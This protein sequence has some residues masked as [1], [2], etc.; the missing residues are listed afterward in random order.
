MR[1][2]PEA[3]TASSSRTLAR[4]L[5]DVGRHRRSQVGDPASAPS[6]PDRRLHARRGARQ[7]VG[8]R[9][10]V[11][12]SVSRSPSTGSA[13]S[14]PAAMTVTAVTSSSAPRRAHSRRAAPVACLS[15]RHPLGG[16]AVAYVA[17]A[18]RAA[19]RWRPSPR[20]CRRSS[21]RPRRA[22]AAGCPGSRRG[23]P[24]RARTPARLA[25]ARIS[26]S[27]WPTIFSIWSL[28]ISVSSRALPARR[29]RGP[30]PRRAAGR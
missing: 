13:G 2:S 4:A 24:P 20:P 14:S 26:A 29:R 25:A 11:G 8:G 23:W 9:A 3:P 16:L 5:D 22:P 17:S 10:L 27:S 1:R 12:R 19:T 28:D 15:A 21:T 30:R 6:S 7:P 18:A